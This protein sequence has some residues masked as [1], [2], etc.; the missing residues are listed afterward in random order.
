MPHSFIQRAGTKRRPAGTGRAGGRRR[1]ST[2]KLQAAHARISKGA[3]RRL[4]RRAGVVRLSGLVYDT[5]GDAL[6]EFLRGVLWDVVTYTEHARRSTV[7]ALDVLH[8]LKLR[9]AHLYGF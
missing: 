1:R 8:A 4:A 7:R 6:Y 9:G 5:A 2:Q 3:I